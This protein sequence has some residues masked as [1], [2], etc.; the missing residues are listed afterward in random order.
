MNFDRI[1]TGLDIGPLLTALGAMPEL[2][3]DITVRQDYP[4]SAHHDTDCIFLRGP[5]SFTPADYFFDLGSYDY[6]AMDKLAVVLVPLLRP[7]LEDVLQVEELGRVLIVRLKPGGV[8]DP[9][10]DEGDYADHF[11]RFHVALTGGAGSTLTVGGETQHFAPGECWWF[12][13]KAEH[14][15]ANMGAEP[16]IHL[17]LDAVAPRYPMPHGART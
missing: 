5:R 8:I 2:W 3:G 7:L 15:G 11:A 6:P 4:G 1:A 13:H 10:V 17:I 12:N 16:R 9:H 14:C